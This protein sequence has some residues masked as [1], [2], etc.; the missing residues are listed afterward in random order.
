MSYSQQIYTFLV[1]SIS[2]YLLKG[3]KKVDLDSNKIEASPRGVLRNSF[4]FLDL[5][6]FEKY[7]RRSSF[8]LANLRL[9]A[10]NFTKNELL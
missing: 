7:L 5:R 6:N 1:E 4:S 2:N 3:E 8:S 9:E 10:Y